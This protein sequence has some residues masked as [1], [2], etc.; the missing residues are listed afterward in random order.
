M[1]AT[2]RLFCADTMIEVRPLPHNIA[3]VQ[4]R[5]DKRQKVRLT[6]E[7]R[8]K[9]REAL[10]EFLAAFL[11]SLLGGVSDQQPGQEMTP[12]HVADEEEDEDEEKQKK[13]K[14]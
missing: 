9:L 13:K 3:S 4:E 12:P 2:E 8:A 10:A 7:Q 5:K 14:S 1:A 6:P 11:H